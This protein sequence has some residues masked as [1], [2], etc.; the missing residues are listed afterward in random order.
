MRRR[1]ALLAAKEYSDL[2]G[3]V[4]MTFDQDGKLSPGGSIEVA[5]AVLEGLGADAIGFNCGLGPKQMATL[6][7]KLREATG[8]A[9]C[10]Q[11]QRWATGRTWMAKP[12][13]TSPLD[14]FASWMGEIARGGAWVVGGCCGTTPE[15]IRK[16]AATC[17]GL[18][19]LRAACPLAY[20]G[21]LGDSVGGIWETT[22]DHR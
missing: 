16:T 5:V 2:P 11:C 7:P 17:A 3:F 19:C 15:H 9:Y 8:T 20:R 6:L 21:H 4:T 13:M 18:S 14:Q 10:S 22:G 12:A 1:L